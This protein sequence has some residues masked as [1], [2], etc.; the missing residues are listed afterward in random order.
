MHRRAKPVMSFVAIDD[1]VQSLLSPL[2]HAIAAAEQAE[3]ACWIGMRR[4]T[5]DTPRT[6]HLARAQQR[7]AL[8]RELLNRPGEEC[9]ARRAAFDAEE[10]GGWCPVVVEETHSPPA[11]VLTPEAAHPVER[12]EHADDGE[13]QDALELRGMCP[14]L[15]P[16]C[17]VCLVEVPHAQMRALVPCGHRCV[18]TPCAMQLE[19]CPICRACIQGLLRVRDV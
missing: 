9:T 10:K 15:P 11:E 7:V 1:L 18:C 19:L 16:A 17:C 4:E 8:E 6:R 13:L 14:R 2:D 12:F 5:G 3:A